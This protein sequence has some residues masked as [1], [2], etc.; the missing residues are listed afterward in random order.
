LRVADALQ[1]AEEA[2]LLQAGEARDGLQAE[3]DAPLPVT[4][5]RA[6][7]RVMREPPYELYYAFE[8]EGGGEDGFQNGWRR[9]IDAASPPEDPQ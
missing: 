6:A 8:I 3:P 1:K 5:A 9:A 7:I 4:M 2:W